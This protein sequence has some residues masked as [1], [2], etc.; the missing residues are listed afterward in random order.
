MLATSER[1][2]QMYQVESGY[3]WKGSFKLDQVAAKA[4]GRVCD[5]S[6]SGMGYRNIGWECETK[7]EAERIV[8]ALE[9]IGLDADY[10]Y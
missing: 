5:F 4:V 7:K 2:K 9:K 3:Q 8:A 1:S 10:Q 6:G